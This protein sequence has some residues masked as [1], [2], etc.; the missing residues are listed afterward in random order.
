MLL[1]RFIYK[2]SSESVFRSNGL[3]N[4]AWLNLHDI[5]RASGSSGPE[6]IDSQWLSP[7]DYDWLKENTAAHGEPEIQ[8]LCII[9]RRK[10]PYRA[11]SGNEA[12]AFF[13]GSSKLILGEGELR[14]RVRR[15][16]DLFA[17]IS[18]VLSTIAIVFSYLTYSDQRDELLIAKKA[19]WNTKLTENGNVLR[20]SSPRE[21]LN[22]QS[23]YVRFSPSTG[24]PPQHLFLP[25]MAISM[26]PL[27]EALTECVAKTFRDDD[28]VQIGMGRIFVP[29]AVATRYTYKG[30]EL[31][32][33]ALYRYFFDIEV[34]RKADKTKTKIIPRGIVFWEH[35]KEGETLKQAFVTFRET[36]NARMRDLIQ[37]KTG[38]LL[39]MKCGA[40][41]EN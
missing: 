2:T 20:F 16:V 8:S 31:V 1:D 25:N 36:D 30:E 29:I 12:T 21:D 5:W 13:A 24:V 3:P 37:D 27:N 10:I 11:I 17:L 41:T 4:G 34:P 15:Q 23:G 33:G 26:L 35:L 22:I 38:T 40:A 7:A 6:P 14:L 39:E 19:I 9:V 18:T 28:H 32:T